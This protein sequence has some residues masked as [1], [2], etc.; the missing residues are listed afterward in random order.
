MNINVWVDKGNQEQMIREYSE[1]NLVF[2]YKKVKEKWKFFVLNKSNQ[3]CLVSVLDI[4][5]IIFFFRITEISK[6]DKANSN[7]ISTYQP[8]WFLGTIKIPLGPIYRK[9][10]RRKK[11]PSSKNLPVS[12]LTSVYSLIF[13]ILLFLLLKLSNLSRP[14]FLYQ[15]TIMKKYQSTCSKMSDL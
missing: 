4:F 5:V 2:M 13:Q 12:D 15:R 9:M 1:N 11:L 6:K 14:S 8:L 10:P 7:S 3:L